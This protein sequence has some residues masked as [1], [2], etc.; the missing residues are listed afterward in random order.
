[1]PGGYAFS[2]DADRPARGNVGVLLAA[3]R[4]RLDRYEE[5][6]RQFRIG[7]MCES[8]LTGAKASVGHRKRPFPA[9]IASPTRQERV[10]FRKPDSS[11]T[12]SRMIGSVRDSPGWVLAGAAEVT[13][14]S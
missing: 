1:M 11:S 6:R 9:S 7:A 8:S 13:D 10:V 2:P 3:A 12:G 5:L 4:T 14:L